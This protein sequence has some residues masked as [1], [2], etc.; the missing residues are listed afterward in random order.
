MSEKYTGSYLHYSI[1]TYR[2]TCC[3]KPVKI[4]CHFRLQILVK[5]ASVVIG[6]QVLSFGKS[7]KWEF[8][9]IGIFAAL[10]GGRK[11]RRHIGRFMPDQER[12]HV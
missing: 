8:I 2:L 4:D 11:R 10:S 6:K 3:G 12:S 9:N 1:D 5:Q 7:E